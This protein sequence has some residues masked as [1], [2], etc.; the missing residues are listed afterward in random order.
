MVFEELVLVQ[1]TGTIMRNRTIAATAAAIAGLAGALL[2]NVAAAQNTPWLV[3]VR[4]LHLDSANKDSTGLGLSIN[5]RFIPELDVSYFFTP[6]LA[7]E[8]VLTYPQKQKLRSNGTQIGEFKHLPPVLSAQY[9]FTSFGAF[10]PYLGAGINYT[11]ISDVEFTPA[12]QAA[13]SPSLDKSSVGFA[14]Q[15]GLDYA[16]SPKLS[17]NFDIKKFQLKTDVKSA[18][19]KVGE[20]KID[21]VL[22]GVGLGYRF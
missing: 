19:T 13:L 11:R 15:A 5:N 3:R 4:A 10:K 7:V 1:T 6:E 14:V 17:L 18:G 2:P 22:V 8:L 12:V 9:H 21:P 20:L 16:L